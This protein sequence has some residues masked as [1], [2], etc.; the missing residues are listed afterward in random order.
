MT[1]SYSEFRAWSPVTDCELARISM[2]DGQSEWFV[3]IPYEGG[4]KYRAAKE[5]AID[6]IVEAMR[7]GLLPGE[8]RIQ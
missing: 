1:L 7:Q 8:V 4:K 5:T 6:M 3:Q 2:T